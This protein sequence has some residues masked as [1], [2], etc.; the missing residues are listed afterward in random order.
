[1]SSIKYKPATYVVVVEGAQP[2]TVAVSEVISRAV[3]TELRASGLI[4]DDQTVAVSPVR[5][6]NSKRKTAFP[7]EVVTPA[8][9]A[10]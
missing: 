2:N 7:K 9:V 8:E 10:A 6:A 3:A 4:S 1:M 5:K